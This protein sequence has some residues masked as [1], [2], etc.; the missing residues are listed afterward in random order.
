MQGCST[1]IACP[2]VGTDS[3]GALFGRC[4]VV[5]NGSMAHRGRR[6]CSIQSCPTWRALVVM[7]TSTENDCIFFSH[8]FFKSREYIN[9]FPQRHTCKWVEVR[10]TIKSHLQL[11]VTVVVDNAILAM[12]QRTIRRKHGSGR[13]QDK[14]KKHDDGHR[15]YL[16]LRS[17][18]LPSRGVVIL[19]SDS[20]MASLVLESSSD[21]RCSW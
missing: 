7:M 3:H 5:D 17:L 11:E 8:Y 1:D 4:L 12:S 6:C 20:L 21:W 18:T 10:R 2:V 13:F 15:L 9:L 16:Y 14:Q 19:D